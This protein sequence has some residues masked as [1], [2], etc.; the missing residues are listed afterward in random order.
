MPVIGDYSLIRME[1]GLLLVDMTPSQPV[2]GWSVEFNMSK[3]FGAGV[4]GLTKLV[5]ASGYGN[6]VS[7]ITI[8]NSGNGNFSVPIS[9]LLTSGLS[10]GNYACSF[11]RTDSGS[12][13]VIYQGY[14]SLGPL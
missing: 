14:L 12:I 13:S 7:G 3:R 5:A 2:G 8:A 10:P 4:S 11:L 9:S 6:G 1:D